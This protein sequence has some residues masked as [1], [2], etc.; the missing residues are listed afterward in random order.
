MAWG[1][2]GQLHGTSYPTSFHTLNTTLARSD[3]NTAQSCQYRETGVVQD[4]YDVLAF[5]WHIALSF[6]FTQ[7]RVIANPAAF[8][9]PSQRVLFGD[10]IEIGTIYSQSDR[11]ASRAIEKYVGPEGLFWNGDTTDP[12]L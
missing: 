5:P 6:P 12:E 4:C 1:V 8:L 3:S 7:G 10:N 9:L 2:Y 11:L